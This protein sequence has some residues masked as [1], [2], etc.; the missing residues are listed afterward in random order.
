MSDSLM[1]HEKESAELARNLVLMKNQ[2]MENNV[3]TNMKRKYA[4]VK[5]GAIKDMPVFVI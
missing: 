3:A 2:I 5:Q 4:A 1:R